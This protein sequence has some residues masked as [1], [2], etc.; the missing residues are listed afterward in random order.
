MG[1]LFTSKTDVI[2]RLIIF[3]LPV[4][5]SVI[6]ITAHIV[7]GNNGAD[8]TAA[9]TAT[10]SV[11]VVSLARAC[12]MIGGH[13]CDKHNSCDYTDNGEYNLVLL[14]G[15]FFDPGFFSNVKPAAFI[16]LCLKLAFYQNYC[17]E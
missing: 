2:Y 11:G 7:S 4:G 9:D 5:K 3:V 17:H 1:V 10:A 12:L 15:V 16:I 14:F 13:I 6:T 8:G